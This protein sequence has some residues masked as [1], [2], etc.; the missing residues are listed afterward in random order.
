MDYQRA[1]ESPYRV[2]LEG[3]LCVCANSLWFISM[4]DDVLVREVY[5]NGGQ[6]TA[7]RNRTIGSTISADPIV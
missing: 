2:P 6:S 1:Y 3:Q 4:L 7:M 5:S